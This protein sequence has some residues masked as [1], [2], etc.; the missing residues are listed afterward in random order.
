MRTDAQ[1]LGQFVRDKDDAAFTELAERHVHLVFSAALRQLNGDSHLAEDVTQAVFGELLRKAPGLVQHPSLAGWL[2][3]TASH[4]AARARRTEARRA[5][6]EALAHAM[7]DPSPTPPEDTHWLELRPVVDD[8]LG[9]LSAADRELILLRFFQDRPFA[10]VGR[11]LGVPENTA[12]MRVERALERLRV[13]LARRGVTSTAALLGS[14][15]RS[16]AITTAPAHLVASLTPAGIAA[17]VSAT[18][19]LP[20]TGALG[21]LLDSLVA[22]KHWILGGSVAA[23]ALSAATGPAPG[24]VRTAPEFDVRFPASPGSATPRRSEAAGPP[25]PAWS[26]ESVESEDY[27]ILIANLR[28][29]GIP[30]RLLRDFIALDLQR[31]YSARAAALKTADEPAPYWRKPGSGSPAPEVQSQLAALTREQ[32]AVLRNLLG[33]DAHPETASQLLWGGP[34]ATAIRLAWLPEPTAH[35]LLAALQ[36]SFESEAEVM[37]RPGEIHGVELLQKEWFR[38][39]LAIARDILDPQQLEEFRWREDPEAEQLR[40]FTRYGEL[41]A[42]DFRRLSELPKDKLRLGRP[43]VT[44]EDFRRLEA[45]A[46]EALGPAKARDYVRALDHTYANARMFTDHLGLPAD[47]ADQVWRIKRETMAASDALEASATA[48]DPGLPARR[49]ALADQATR[50]IKALLGDDGFRMVR[51]D[52]PWWKNLL[53]PGSVPANR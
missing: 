44:T 35:R 40:V 15:L 46:A 30:E 48:G 18:G 2:H 37:G 22:L 13:R 24:P 6:R 32:G 4:I 19:L 34:D 43:A 17:S 42:D 20:A 16:H 1:L 3:L 5:R 8:V 23:L 7:S 45:D 26:W 25:G 38:E 36:P 52:W 14:A 39:R 47:V 27:R 53:N 29:T 49:Q 9:A 41:S 11:L 31:H 21:H 10:E 28:A 33:P 51:Q 12:R 50:N